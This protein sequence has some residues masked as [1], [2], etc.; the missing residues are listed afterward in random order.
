MARRRIAFVS[1]LLA[2]CAASLALGAWQIER[3]TAKLALIAAVDQRVHAAPVPAPGPS[4]WERIS[5]TA[6][7]YRRITVSGRFD[8]ARATRVEAVTG[9]GPGKWLVTPLRTEAGWTVL[10][11]RGFVPD[12]GARA[13][14]PAGPVRVVGLLRVTEPH[15][16]FLRANVP[17]EDRWYSRD[18]AAIAARRGLGLVAPYFIDADGAPNAGGYPLGGLTVIHFRNAHLGYALTWFALAGLSAWGL[19]RVLRE[20]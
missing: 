19:S 11:N 15:G 16:A 6:D 13:F 9:R 5:A 7:A 2:V 4:Q 12:G 20:P 8:H 17:A 14:E 3:R 1:L 18:V 10:V